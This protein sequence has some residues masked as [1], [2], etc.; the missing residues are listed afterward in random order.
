MILTVKTKDTVL[1]SKGTT[2]ILRGLPNRSIQGGIMD[3]HRRAALQFDCGNFRLFTWRFNW[4]SAGQSL[5][6]QD[7]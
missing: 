6:T 1:T 2:S 3:F 5:G 7:T 4:Q